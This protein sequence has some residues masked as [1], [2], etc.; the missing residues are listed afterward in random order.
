MN[1][2]SINNYSPNYNANFKGV[3]KHAAKNVSNS[4]L[5]GVDGRIGKGMTMKYAIGIMNRLLAVSASHQLKRAGVKDVC[6]KL[7]EKGPGWKSQI[8]VGS[9]PNLLLQVTMEDYEQI[10]HPM[11]MLSRMSGNDGLFQVSI[12]GTDKKVKIRVPAEELTKNMKIIDSS[13]QAGPHPF[14]K[15]MADFLNSHPEI[16]EEIENQAK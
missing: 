2:Y 5:T 7:I 6:A 8:Q 9:N 1:I 11:C 3:E 4:V 16:V 14:L 12:A 10:S 15:D 13:I